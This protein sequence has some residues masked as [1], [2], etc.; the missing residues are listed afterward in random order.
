MIRK[1]TL[2]DSADIQ[3]LISDWARTGKVLDRPLNYVYEH[4][5]DYWVYCHKGSIV[6]CCALGVVGW[7]G[8]AEI[9][10]LI[11]SKKYQKKG[12][13]KGLVQACVNEASSLRVEKVFAL[14]YV[15]GFFK[16]LGFKNIDRK[17][18]PHKIWSDCINCPE[19]PDCGEEAVIVKVAAFLAKGK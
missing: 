2:D 18:L 3:S 17:K 15:S 9:K 10:S 11:V 19:F 16:K 5:R 12:F 14:T 13:G 4:I 6:G 8:L 1:A 7:Q